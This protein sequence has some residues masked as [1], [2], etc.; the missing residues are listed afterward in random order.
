MVRVEWKN[1]D[2]YETK[3]YAKLFFNANQIPQTYPTDYR[4][5]SNVYPVK[6]IYQFIVTWAKCGQVINT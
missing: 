3:L 1:D 4:P 6:I 2:P 5:A